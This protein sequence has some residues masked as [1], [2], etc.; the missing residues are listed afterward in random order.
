M[1]LS[2]IKNFFSK[3]KK[4]EFQKE[5]TSWL[6]SHRL[7][8][9]TNTESLFKS[10]KEYI[11][12]LLALEFGHDFTCTLRLTNYHITILWRGNKIIGDIYYYFPDRCWLADD[13]PHPVC[14]VLYYL[15]DKLN[16]LEDD[17][18]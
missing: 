12:D 11:D 6:K 1:I 8:V 4:Y 7:P 14:K 9:A 18:L 2:K 16:T 17:K 13:V 5:L 15:R 3:N 10:T